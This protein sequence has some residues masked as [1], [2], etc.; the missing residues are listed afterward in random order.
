M[1]G[2]RLEI[3]F[4]KIGH[5]AR[6]LV[7]RAAVRNVSVTA[8]TKAMLG[9]TELARVLCTAGAVALGDSRIENIERLRAAGVGR[10]TLLL[11]SPMMSQ[12]DRVVASGSMSVNTEPAVLSALATAARRAGR[13]HDV[14]LMVELGDLREGVMPDQLHATVQHVVGLPALRLQGIGANLACRNGIEPSV[15]NMGDL[16]DMVDSV[17]AAFGIEIEIVSGGNSAN[18]DWA[19]GTTAIGRINNLRLGESILL[20][21]EP[22]HRRALPGLHTDA[23]RLVAEVIE[24][25]RKPTMPW[26]RAGQ[27]SFGEMPRSEDRGDIWQTILAVGRQDCDSDDLTAPPG[28]AVLAASSDHLVV[29]TR[30]RMSPGDEI[31]FEPGYSAL[32]R[33]MTSPFV[34][35]VGL[36][37]EA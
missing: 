36:P 28:V 6:Q 35:K 5:N 29:E 26:G 2:L 8:V 4:D 22:L 7:E 15:E 16:S 20:G 17:E 1:T 12:V 18:V 37:A 3:D 31:R 24:S 21:R 11:R 13:V 25:K 19:L 33:S 14:M 30:D 32:L 9:S 27:N 10:P 23:F 34:T